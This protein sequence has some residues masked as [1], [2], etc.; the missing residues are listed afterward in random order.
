MNHDVSP[1]LKLK[2][3]YIT[4]LYTN[5]ACFGS[6]VIICVGHVDETILIKAYL[7]DCVT[8][9]DYFGNITL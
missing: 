8:L 7:G 2:I 4:Q 3:Y 1:N 6:F 5:G 9:Y